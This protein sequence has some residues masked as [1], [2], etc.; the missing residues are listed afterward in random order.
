M[1]LF[2]LYLHFH[3]FSFKGW[4]VIKPQLS[5]QIAGSSYPK[6]IIRF[7]GTIVFVVIA[8][9]SKVNPCPAEPGY[10]LPLQTV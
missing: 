10:T 5:N 1:F 7:K 9:T 4:H 2:L 6:D 8:N 3:S